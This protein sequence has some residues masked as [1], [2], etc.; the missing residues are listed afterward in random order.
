MPRGFPRVAYQPEAHNYRELWRGRPNEDK[1]AAE[2]TDVA[3]SGGVKFETVG[4][5]GCVAKL[6]RACRSAIDASP[7]PGIPRVVPDPAA[8]HGEGTE[9]TIKDSWMKRHNLALSDSVLLVRPS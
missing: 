8:G 1:L 4:D 9:K 3:K 2:V 7:T 6:W 5:K